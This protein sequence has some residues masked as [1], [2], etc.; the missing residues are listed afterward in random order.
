MIDLRVAY[1]FLLSLIVIKFVVYDL[2]D[3]H[4][5]FHNRDMIEALLVNIG[6]FDDVAEVVERDDVELT[7]VRRDS[8]RYFRLCRLA[9]LFSC[10]EIQEYVCHQG[11]HF[12]ESFNFNI[13]LILSDL[14]PELVIGEGLSGCETGDLFR[15]AT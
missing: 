11:E 8:L 1:Y 13:W 6:W 12:R 14:E 7:E 4:S 9:L 10:L 15:Q 2:F 3:Q 5:I